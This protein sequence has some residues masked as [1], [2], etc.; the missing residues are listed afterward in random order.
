MVQPVWGQ[1]LALLSRV[2]GPGLVGAEV[3]EP[4]GVARLVVAVPVAQV[5][6]FQSRPGVG[7]HPLD[8]VVVLAALPAERQRE[9]HPVPAR[10]PGHEALLLQGGGSHPGQF[11]GG[12]GR[13][14]PAQELVQPEG[15]H[16][17]LSGGVLDSLAGHQLGSD[18]SGAR[19]LVESGQTGQF[20]GSA[21]EAVDG[22][23]L[24][25]LQTPVVGVLF[26]SHARLAEAHGRLGP[27]QAPVVGFGHPEDGLDPRRQRVG[28]ETV[29]VG[30]G[31]AGVIDPL[32][33]P[34]PFLF[35]AGEGAGGTAER[36][37]DHIAVRHLVAEQLRGH[38]GEP[39]LP[40]GR[41]ALAGQ[42]GRR[43]HAQQPR[44]AA[45]ARG[46]GR[47]LAD[48]AHQHGHVGALATPVG[49][50]FV[51]HQK[52]QVPELLPQPAVEHPGE[53]QLQHHVV[54]QQDVGGIGQDLI[55]NIVSV[56]AGVALIGHRRTVAPRSVLQEL[57]QLLHLAVGQGVHRVHHHG[58]GPLA[59]ASAQDVVHDWDDV[60]QA[61]ARPGARGQQIVAPGLGGFD[62]LSLVPVQHKPPAPGIA[63][64]LAD[65]E[66]AG[67]VGMQHPGGGEVVDGPARLEARVEGQH[68]MRPHRLVVESRLELPPQVG[69]G[70]AHEARRVAPILVDQPLPQVEHVHRPPTLTARPAPDLATNSIRP[71]ANPASGCWQPLTGLDRFLA[72]GG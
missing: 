66:D 6:A 31:G 19:L 1:P 3:E 24:G 69:I 28:L 65:A 45:P 36:L 62:G 54:G 48:S 70:N 22:P 37:A 8:H 33:Q 20:P 29:G 16:R 21:A 55:P 46:P 13:V 68:G 67:R 14:A 59:G 40:L 10:V 56:L 17:H 39:G 42:G 52:A 49:V 4:G 9:I 32:D 35:G 30:R 71:A 18:G 12:P 47:G 58:L 50:Q 27:I 25:P 60:G 11:G 57:V 51:E 23:R 72:R 41:A 34:G 64:A 7:G 53:D 43:S 63:L 44:A 38:G 61:L 5:P 2:V 15:E 26:T